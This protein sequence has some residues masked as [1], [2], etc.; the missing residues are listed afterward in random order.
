MSARDPLISVVRLYLGYL[1]W[2]VPVLYL[3]VSFPWARRGIYLQE[4]A[5]EETPFPSF[6]LVAFC[7]DPMTFV[8]EV[9]IQD[10]EK[11]LGE[12]QAK[13]DQCSNEF[14]NFDR[15]TPSKKGR[16][17]FNTRLEE[18]REAA[19]MARSVLDRHADRLQFMKSHAVPVIPVTP[20]DT[21]PTRNLL[22][23]NTTG[24]KPHKHK[25]KLP[26]KFDNINTKII[27]KEWLADVE[28]Y[29]AQVDCCA[30]CLTLCEFMS[31]DV[32][33]EMREF[34]EEYPNPQLVPLSDCI[35]HLRMLYTNESSGR[36]ARSALLLTSTRAG[37]T[38]EEWWKSYER[39]PRQQRPDFL[40][41]WSMYVLQAD[42]GTRYRIL[43]KLFAGLEGDSLPQMSMTCFREITSKACGDGEITTHDDMLVDTVSG[44]A[45]PGSVDKECRLFASGK[46]RFGKKCIFK[47]T[48][49]KTPPVCFNCGKPGHFARDCKSAP[50]ASGGE[51]G[52]NSA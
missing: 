25:P 41:C 10:M 27:F 35:H 30:P 6:K 11:E 1:W 9:V 43:S 24:P 50:P 15:S 29:F 49:T 22:D 31:A 4:L 12:L 48:T 28:S 20:T 18:L 38:H 44:R 2:T 3:G 42:E 46:C 32:L 16:P 5:R 14:A 26:D 52:G 19:R 23:Y 45:L 8:P 21:V 7:F 33:V 40:W 34:F 51:G 36:H 13:F 39:V 17:G 37:R 47:H